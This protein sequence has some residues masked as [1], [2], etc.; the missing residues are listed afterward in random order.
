MS[1][2][3]PYHALSEYITLKYQS[4]ICIIIDTTKSLVDEETESRSLCKQTG[5][6]RRSK[7]LLRA[8]KRTS[9]A[10]R[11]VPRLST[12]E[13]SA[14]SCLFTPRAYQEALAHHHRPCGFRVI[15]GPSKQSL[16]SQKPALH[17]WQDRLLFDDLS[18][19]ELFFS[20]IWEASHGCINPSQI[21]R[22][23]LQ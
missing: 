15:K 19:P 3:T 20:L 21:A 14:H 4:E 9:T 23:V 6:S 1:I 16:F 12:Y 8:I 17:L 22:D 5:S 13:R 18:T 2:W 7:H 11:S 10:V